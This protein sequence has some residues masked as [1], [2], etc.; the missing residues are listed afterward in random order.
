ME[1]YVNGWPHIHLDVRIPSQNFVNKSGLLSFLGP[2]CL[3][4]RARLAEER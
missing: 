2:P 3:N 4:V 1:K